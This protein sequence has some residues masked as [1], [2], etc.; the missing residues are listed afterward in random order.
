[1]FVLTPDQYALGPL[2]GFTGEIFAL[3]WGNPSDQ[4]ARVHESGVGNL[5]SMAKPQGC[6]PKYS[7]AVDH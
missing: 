7:S 6:N 1:M 2:V 5:Q 3:F 4:S